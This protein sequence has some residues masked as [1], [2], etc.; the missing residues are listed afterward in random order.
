[1]LRLQ[2]QA[3]K[4]AAIAATATRG[5]VFLQENKIKKY[6][7]GTLG[8]RQTPVATGN[9]EE[10]KTSSRENIATFYYSIMC[11]QVKN[12]I[13]SHA[14]YYLRWCASWFQA[15][16]ELD[17]DIVMSCP[18]PFVVFSHAPYYLRWCASWFQARAE[19]DDDI[20]MS[21]PGP[22]VVSSTYVSQDDRPSSP[23]MYYRHHL[24]LYK[25]QV[26][27]VFATSCVT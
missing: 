3:R 13:F 17:D 5:H 27:S 11:F 21:C 2:D 22:F 25:V 24:R 12:E 26:P 7:V 15:R 23:L 14:P 9:K 1:M 16:A 10:T 8:S 18:G 20:V 4:G 6:Y 19:L